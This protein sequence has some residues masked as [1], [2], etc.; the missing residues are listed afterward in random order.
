M[1][2]YV[3]PQDQL[4]LTDAELNEEHARILTAAN[5]QIPQNIVRYSYKVKIS[6]YI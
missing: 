3:K 4:V 1:Y 2:Q 6:F 5:N